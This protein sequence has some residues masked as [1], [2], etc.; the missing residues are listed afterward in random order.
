VLRTDAPWAPA[1]HR[2]AWSQGRLADR[3]VTDGFDGVTRNRR[4]SALAGGELHLGDAVFDAASGR[5]VRLGD[6]EL[7]GPRLDVYRAPIENDRGQ[8]GNNDLAA[9]WQAVGIDRMQQRTDLVEAGDRGIRVIGR[10]AASTHPHALVYRFDWTADDDGLVLE[11]TVEFTGPWADTP[12][13]HRDIVLP[14][15]GLRLGLPGGYREATWFGRGPGESYVDSTA[16]ARVGRF[17]STID[18][19]QVHYPV[20]QENG[21]HV[22][23]RWLELTGDEVPTLRVAGDPVFDFTARRWTSEDL[24]R[25]RHPH[26]LVD[27]GRVWLNVDHRQLGL[28]SASCGPA[29]PERHRVPRETTSWRVRF[30]IEDSV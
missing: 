17:R 4:R 15:L 26:D 9:V 22:E 2:V 28:G 18:D 11:A 30:S 16:A 12:Y 23:T 21:N 13:R 19:L 20:P 10:S 5:L 27:S 1:G 25:A 14:R 8:G 6:L 29:L 24:E 3:R 7:D